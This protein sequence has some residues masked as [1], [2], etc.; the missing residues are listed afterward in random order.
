MAKK[1]R[2]QEEKKIEKSYKDNLLAKR[3][4]TICHNSFLI[5]IKKGDV[6]ESLNIP[7][8]FFTNLKTENVI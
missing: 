5:K 7:Q 8:K 1:E 2:E 4:F 3:D 6:I